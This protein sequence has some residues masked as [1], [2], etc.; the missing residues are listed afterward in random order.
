MSA[1]IIVI[2]LVIVVLVALVTSFHLAHFTNNLRPFPQLFQM[3]SIIKWLSPSPTILLI[4]ASEYLLHRNCFKLFHLLLN[5]IISELVF[6]C[7]SV[8]WVCEFGDS[9]LHFYV[10]GRGRGRL[11]TERMSVCSIRAS[12]FSI[13][14]LLSL[15]TFSFPC[16]IARSS[17]YFQG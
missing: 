3:L 2:R 1:N 9:I 10:S 4:S 13:L 11:L 14:N 6:P 5:L 17:H 12:F 7:I 8:M 16:I 15:F